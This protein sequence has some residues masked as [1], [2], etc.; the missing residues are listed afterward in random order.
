MPPEAGPP[1]DQPRAFTSLLGEDAAG[2]PSSGDQ[3]DPALVSDIN[4]DQIVTAVADGWGERELIS[5]LLY[6]RAGKTSTVAYRQ[7]VFLDLEDAGLFRAA[8]QFAGR[9]DQVHA[10]LGQLAGLRSG[11]QRE[12]WFLDAGAIYCDAVRALA[13]D[14]AASPVAS[15]GLLAFREYLAAYAGSAGFARLAADTADRKH[16]LAQVTY[17]VRIKGARVEVNRYDGE[18]DYSAEMAKTFERFQQ[19]A[20]K[21]YRVQY[22]TWPGMNHVGAQIARPG[23]PLVPA[24]VLGAG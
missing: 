23:R 17:Q 4:L 12:G 22:R 2:L 13:A 15:R 18:P 10:H 16:D 21:D 24:G 6:Q 5:Q 7:E 8:R 1:A 14:L 20:V 9:M 19:G 3:P 11:H